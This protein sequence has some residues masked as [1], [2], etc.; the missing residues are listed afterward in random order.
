[1]PARITGL[2]DFVMI[3]K[4]IKFSHIYRVAI[5]SR[6]LVFCLQFFAVNLLPLHGNDGFKFDD[7]ENIADVRS[8]DGVVKFMFGGFTNWDGQIG[9][10]RDKNIGSGFVGDLI[11]RIN[12]NCCLFAYL[13]LQTLLA[14]FQRKK[15]TGI[16]FAS[17]SA[18]C[19]S[20]GILNFG[21]C[22]A[23]G[24]HEILG[25]YKQ[26]TRFEKLQ[27]A[28]RI[29]WEIVLVTIGLLP[30]AGFQLFCFQKFCDSE[31]VF[32]LPPFCFG[33][34]LPY[35][36]IQSEH[37]NVGFLRYFE[38]KQLPNFIL[39]APV[40]FTLG[41]HSLPGL[42]EFICSIIRRRDFS[43]LD[44]ASTSL[45]GSF[46]TVFCLTSMH[47]QVSTRLILSSCPYLYVLIG[48]AIRTEIFEFRLKS[49][50]ILSYS[51]YIYGWFLTYFLVGCLAF[52][53]GYPWT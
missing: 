10:G 25:Q 38:M 6:I 53:A 17:L 28:V 15:F 50:S 51:L 31:H 3:N 41:K 11:V 39:A 8:L 52:P 27:A 47:V 26:S 42:F 22:L 9:L 2:T 1:M 46:L 30:F 36:Y 33:T 35:Q 18:V 12:C 32:P 40:L 24:A 43:S 16:W 19:R 20:N 5:C 7:E 14:L 23:F 13:T 29:L 37:W 34:Q 21:F 4:P 48:K 45:H 44:L 49:K